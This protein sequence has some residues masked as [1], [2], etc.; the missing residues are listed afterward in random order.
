LTEFLRLRN[1]NTTGI[2]PKITAIDNIIH[3]IGFELPPE[4]R[5]RYKKVTPTPKTKAKMMP[6]TM[7]FDLPSNRLIKNGD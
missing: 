3:N 1:I 5:W 2:M 4:L 7:D 6:N